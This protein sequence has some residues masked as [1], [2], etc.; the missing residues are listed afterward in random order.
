MTG[1]GDLS[2][3][4]A[5]PALNEERFIEGVI[6]SLSASGGSL[7]KEIFVADGGSSD[8]T[9]DIVRRL[10]K[11]DGR[12]RLIDNPGRIQSSGLN[13]ILH[14]ATASIFLRADAHCIYAEDYI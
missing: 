5:I 1:T 11:D 4:I 2:V 7:V 9:R 8:A 12:I 10:M 13:L 3:C 14:E 6:R